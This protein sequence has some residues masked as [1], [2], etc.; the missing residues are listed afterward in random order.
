MLLHFLQSCG[1]L[2]CWLGG[3]HVWQ[4]HCA[5]LRHTWSC[6]NLSR[7]GG[8][9]VHRWA[10]DTQTQM[11]E[12]RGDLIGCVHGRF[13]HQN[14]VLRRFGMRTSRTEGLAGRDAFIDTHARVQ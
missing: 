14:L 1:T 8:D 4:M 2:W 3:F 10:K 5:S 9:S 11:S 6:G 12:L 13:L 7:S